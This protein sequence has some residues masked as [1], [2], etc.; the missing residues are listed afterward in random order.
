MKFIICKS[1]SIVS[2]KASAQDMHDERLGILENINFGRSHWL[3]IL[4]QYD[5]HNKG[6][7][8]HNVRNANW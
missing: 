1:P 3:V 2:Q 8:K 5:K 7:D 6:Y 4:P